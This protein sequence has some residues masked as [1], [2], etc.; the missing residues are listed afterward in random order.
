M[1]PSFGSWSRGRA[2]DLASLPRGEG[3][4]AGICLS[5][6][7]SFLGMVRMR[8]VATVARPVSYRS[9]GVSVGGRGAWGVP[10]L[11]P[12]RERYGEIPARE[13]ALVRLQSLG[14]TFFV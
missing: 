13:E 10:L 6:F 9:A 12:L 7:V 4:D 2:H 11:D 3:V 1:G 14:H 8:R 5:L